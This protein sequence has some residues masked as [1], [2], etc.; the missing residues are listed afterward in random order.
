[1]RSTRPSL[2]PVVLEP[3]QTMADQTL[4]PSRKN[5][6]RHIRPLSPPEEKETRVWDLKSFPS[7]S[8]TFFYLLCCYSIPGTP[9][10]TFVKAESKG[11]KVEKIKK[12]RDTKKVRQ[13]R[14]DSWHEN[15]LSK[16]KIDLHPWLT[17][18]ACISIQIRAVSC[19]RTAV[20][21][22]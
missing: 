18:G 22:S 12:G 14:S 9:Q 19:S 11:K 10:D 15:Y 7:I 20:S 16:Y 3:A 1:M 5:P 13:Q 17:P 8:V 6:S 4:W 2:G 21:C